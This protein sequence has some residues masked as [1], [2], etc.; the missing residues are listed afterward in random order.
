MPLGSTRKDR[1][2]LH[3]RRVPD[4]A[5]LGLAWFLSPWPFIRA[6]DYATGI[7]ANAP[8]LRIFAVAVPNEQWALL[9]VGVASLLAI[10]L[11]FRV[12]TV[13]WFGHMLSCAAYVGAAISVAQG[14]IPAGDGYRSIG[15]LLVIATL[16]LGLALLLGPLP[17]RKE[18]SVDDAD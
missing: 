11:V 18:W 7:D 3:Y 1:R 9:F 14:A 4:W 5:P 15:P 2:A 16:H 8:A 10:G 12:H 6:L 17:P 13:T